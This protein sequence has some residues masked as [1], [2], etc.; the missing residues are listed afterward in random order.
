[1]IGYSYVLKIMFKCP[2]TIHL[3]KL[4][5]IQLKLET[6]DFAIYHQIQYQLI[7][8]FLP[9]K[10]FYSKSNVYSLTM[11]FNDRSLDLSKQLD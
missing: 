5:E 3:L 1:M 6:G 2:K 9:P 8:A 11:A 10:V 7:M 4:L